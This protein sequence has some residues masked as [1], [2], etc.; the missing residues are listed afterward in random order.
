MVVT[1]LDNHLDVET[2]T[3]AYNPVNVL[4]LSTTQP[5]VHVPV[6]E[7]HE[8]SLLIYALA[9]VSPNL[10]AGCHDGDSRHVAEEDTPGTIVEASPR[11]SHII[12]LINISSS[13]V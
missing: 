11:P 1:T 5:V 2:N 10:H 7:D 9:E 12:I 6:L 4:L 13:L 8:R 3:L